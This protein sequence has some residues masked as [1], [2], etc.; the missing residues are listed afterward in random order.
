MNR[1][2]K[3]H[4]LNDEVNLGKKWNLYRNNENEIRSKEKKKAKNRAKNKRR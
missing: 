3:A 4:I 2:E 1:L